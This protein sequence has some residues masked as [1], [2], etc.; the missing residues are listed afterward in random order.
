M[1]ATAK[2]LKS[3]KKHWRGSGA[4][5]G[6]KS[7][8]SAVRHLPLCHTMLWNTVSE[9]QA[10]LK[11]S[12]ALADW[13]RCC[14][15]PRSIPNLPQPTPDS[16]LLN[17]YLFSTQRKQRN[18]EAAIFKHTNK[19][20]LISE[21]TKCNRGP[22]VQWSLLKGQ[23]ESRSRSSLFRC[24]ECS[25]QRWSHSS[26]RWQHSCQSS[27]CTPC[28]RGTGRHNQPYYLIYL[29]NKGDRTTGQ[30]QSFPFLRKMSSLIFTEI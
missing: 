24:Q 27:W 15:L 22:F 10:N 4:Q 19:E 26:L 28:K 16:L 2:S 18:V 20:P 21:C 13:N 3:N 14:Q 12:F 30:E 23:G 17:L 1:E 29:N 7:L 11:H 5:Q 8:W 9:K 6:K 25:M